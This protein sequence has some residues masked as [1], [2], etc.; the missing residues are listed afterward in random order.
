[1]QDAEDGREVIKCY[2]SGV[3]ASDSDDEKRLAKSRRQAR[4]NKKK[5]IQRQKAQL[6]KRF[7]ID[8]NTYNQNIKK[9]LIRII[10]MFVAYKNTQFILKRRI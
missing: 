7:E 1:M 8:N 4:I 5:K 3:L 2:E 10:I 9:S 6:Y